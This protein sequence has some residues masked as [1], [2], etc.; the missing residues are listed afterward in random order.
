MQDP[1]I[2]KIW[3]MKI[4][5]RGDALDISFDAGTIKINEVIPFIGSV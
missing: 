5:G 1:R 2:N 3:N 4:K